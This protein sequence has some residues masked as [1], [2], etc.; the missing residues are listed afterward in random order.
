MVC[1]FKIMIVIY[2]IVTIVPIVT[3]T[4]LK[5]VVNILYWN[6]TTQLPHADQAGSNRLKPDTSTDQN[7]S[8]TH[9]EW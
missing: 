8:N 4:N 5:V 1:H 3:I 2:P 7:I 6:Y 9:I